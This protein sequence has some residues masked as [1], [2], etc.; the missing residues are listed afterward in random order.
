MT[1]LFLLSAAALGLWLGQ[2]RIIGLFVAGLNQHLAVPVRARRLEVSVL[3]QFPRLSVTLHDVVVSGSQPQDTTRLLRARR[4]FCA[5]DATDL[6]AGRYR[7]RAITLTN[8][9]LNVRRDARGA[10]NYHLLRSDTTAPANAPFGLELEDIRLERVRLTYADAARRQFFALRT[11]GLRAA[12]DVT[13]ARL[14]VAASGTAQMETIRLGADDYFRAKDL[15]LR[16]SLTID[17]AGQQLT[18]RP[19]EIGVGAAAYTVAGTVGYAGAPRLNLTAAARQTDAQALLALLPPRLTRGL[20]GYRSRGAVYFEGSVRGEWSGQHNPAVAVR[21]GCREASFFHP[22]YRQAIDHVSLQGSFSNGA[23]QTAASS[24]LRLKQ[25]RGQLAGRPFSGALVLRDFRTPT[26]DLSLLADLDMAR[27][28]RFFPVAAV[29]A[30]QGE[31]RLRLELHGPVAALRR[32]PT[33]AQAHGELSLRGVMLRL[34]DFRQP[35]TG[36]SARLE[37]RGA[38]VAV[39]ELRGRLGHSDFR[40]SATLRNVAGWA[41]RPGQPLRVEANLSS[42]LLDFNQ[43][44]YVYQPAAPG[45]SGGGA[46][47]TSGGL[48]VPPNLVLDVRAQAGQVRFRRLRGR[49]LRGS[50]RL[51]NQVFSSAGLSLTAAGGQLSAH[52]TVDARQPRLLKASTVASC[53]QV[54]L[55]SLFYVFEDFGQQFITSRHLRGT[56]TATAVSDTYFDGR[57][58]PLPDRLEAQV[59]A[60]VRAGALLNFEPLQKLSLVADRATLRHLRFAEL[61]NNFYI[62]SRTVYVPEMDIR[63]NVRAAALIRITGTHTFDQQLDYHVRI[64]L[65]PGLLPR[66]A[67]RA[68]GPM[69]RLAIRG[70]ES[71]FTVRYETGSPTLPA[72]RPAPAPVASPAAPGPARPAAKP[73]WEV[74]KPA[75]KPAEPQVGDYFEF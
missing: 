50:L 4:L 54:P 62:Q 58:T 38:D 46:A 52:G 75:K 32:Q 15:R 71:N 22:E 51:R 72:A 17:R 67:A 29:Q 18:I 11:P 55:D 2:D 66:A 31:A 61:H 47:S 30:A 70:T 36:L 63:S 21:F 26:L 23:Q 1:L 41:S 53:Q 9:Q 3:D 37:L 20:A 19:S 59:Q 40:G 65:L 73:S 7:I 6:L 56:L 16:V 27:A 74:K 60:T 57:L 13:E 43:L 45:A 14:N 24:V 68:D 12:V 49:A 25:V 44:L 39:R 10:G 64:P 34:R 33:A 42:E 48:H 5:F 35:F 8:G 28:V 69:L